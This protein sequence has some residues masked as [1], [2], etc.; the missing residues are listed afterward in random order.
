MATDIGIASPGELDDG[1]VVALGS[2]FHDAV[3]GMAVVGLDGR[4][5]RVNR[6]LCAML[7]RSEAELVGMRPLDVTHP[8]DQP[9]AE[10]TMRALLDGRLPAHEVRKRYV[11]PDGTVVVGLRTT[12]VLRDGTGA[13]RG[14]FSQVIDV[15]AT[16]AAEEALERSE[17][18]FRA[19][20]AH[21]TEL[22]VLLDRGGSIT[23]VSPAS[24]RL[25]GHDPEQCTGR[26]ARD[27]LHPDDLERAL[28]AFD[29][30]PARRRPAGPVEMRVRHRDGSW[31][32][33][34]VVATDLF[35]DPDVAAMVL[36]VRD[37]SDERH[38]Q[39]QLAA[40]E[41]RLRALVGSAWD[42]ITL[43]GRD[44]RCLY[45]SPAVT[46]LLGY[47]PDDLVGLHPTDLIHPDDLGNA[48]AYQEA[49]ATTAPG[50]AFQYRF[51]TKAGSWRW[52]ESTA[53]NRLDDPAIGGVVVVTRDVSARR[54]RAAQQ[55]AVAALGRHALQ[56]GSLQVL[57]DR[58][59][60]LVAEALDVPHSTVLRADRTGA[61][62][63]AETTL[64]A[65]A[66]YGPPMIPGPFA[67][68]VDGR[69]V[70]T[71]ARALLE[72]RAQVW[73]GEHDG[74]LA[75]LH[76]ALRQA[77]LRSGAATVIAGGPPGPFGALAVYATA[78]DAFSCDDLSFLESTANVLAAAIARWR[79]EEELRRRALHDELTG[80]PNRVLLLDRLA[81]ALTRLARR[82][83]SVAAIFVDADDL[84][85]VNDSLGHAAGDQVVR[86]V[87]DR[88]RAAV[89]PSDTV[90][91]FGGDE[92]A[93]LCDET[94]AAEAR[95]I[96]DR[97]RAALQEPV[98]LGGTSVVV[99]VSMGIAVT[100]D[101]ACTPDDLLAEADT[102]MYAAKRAGKDRAA[103]F[104]VRM[105]NAVTEQLDTASGL[106][107]AVSGEE[108]RLF[109]QPVVDA[110]TG[111][112]VGGEALVRWQHPRRG[113]LGP[114]T[115]IEQAEASGLIVAV[116]G[117]VMRTA[118]RQ[119]AN[120]GAGGFGGN[121]SINVSA[122][123]L[124][125]PGIVDEVCRAIEAAGAEPSKVLIEVTESAVMSDLRRSAAV[126]EQL[127]SLGVRVG[128]DDF[129]TG[130][131]SLS[132]LADLPFDFLKIDR[133]FIARLDR[134]RRAAALLETLASLCQSLELT[135]IAEG[136]ETEEQLQRVRSVG[137]PFIQGFLFGRPVP[138]DEFPI[139]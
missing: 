93:I 54:R 62:T 15:T 103:T 91:R 10:A 95:Q 11:R 135:A 122:R 100:T 109:Y 92:I 123:Q 131:S 76:P 84:K 133:S 36:N 39:A 7:G 74:E 113:L 51:R 121:V 65:V 130:Y 55:D 60:T 75:G 81:A 32:T 23:Y 67:I 48:A 89:R 66:R 99:T 78:P 128:I 52:L 14:L 85:L 72:G 139:R 134:D 132:Y 18:R 105:R 46:A 70:S 56:G 63:A 107:Q 24:T 25:L 101:P 125:E 64:T 115:F 12:T 21:A 40:S 127:G 104:D 138:P 58:A 119:V 137:I 49:L 16:T 8:D 71:A 17:R 111:A 28:A 117:W 69:P 57:F 27:F 114:G 19:L 3:T 79:M 13:V 68:T 83:G 33:V 124:A 1:Q 35:D 82:P 53:H 90:A 120:W 50:A 2:A 61:G 34:E 110:T 45:V 116:G 31:H 73:D 129:G 88:V 97:L 87:A 47:D 108:L 118:C 42:I 29:V 38:Y 59:V 41:Q 5:A 94:D 96:A 20:V 86:A 106:R 4:F 43:H 126:I 22:T 30:H 112:V 9:V 98:D 102:A 6:A 26:P 80:L 136:V 37:I 44:G 77:G